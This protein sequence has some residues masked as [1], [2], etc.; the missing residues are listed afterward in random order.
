MSYQLSQEDRQLYLKYANLN[1]PRHTSYPI[2]PAWHTDFQGKN[3]SQS[4]QKLAGKNQAVSLYFHIPFCQRLC[5]YC[6]C[7]KEIK[8]TDTTLAMQMSDRYI[9]HLGLEVE[10]IAEQTGR[11]PV[12]QIHLGGGSPTYLSTAHLNKLWSLID[13]Y[14]QVEKTAEVAVEVDPRITSEEQIKELRNLGVNRI[15]LGVQDFDPK[16]QQAVNR[17]QPY[18]QVATFVEMLHKYNFDSLN[19]DLIYGLPFQNIESMTDTLNKVQTLRPDR[20][21]FYRLAMIPEMFKW[22]RSFTNKDMPA[23]ELVLDLFLLAHNFLTSSDYEYIGFDHFAKTEEGLAKALLDGSVQRNFQGIT[24]GRTLPLIGFGPSAISHLEDCFAQ[25][26]KKSE[27]WNQQVSQGFATERG[28]HLSM[29]DKIRAEVLQQLYCYGSIKYGS[30][31]QQFGIVFKEYFAKELEKMLLYVTEGLVNLSSERLSLSEPLG[32][33]LARVPAVLF[34]A[35]FDKILASAAESGRK[36]S[37]SS[38][39]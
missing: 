33:L 21:A 18:E 5:Y 22:Q 24:T 13:R 26:V 6:G 28:L 9:E 19:F 14:F 16:V 37:F 7:N 10:R 2:A 36:K 4:L 11:L 34:D 8:G 25:N 20:I 29:D 32:R 23:G 39:G 17:L 31:E 1:L 27:S 12:A 38:V 30:V 3:F 35:Y 15:S